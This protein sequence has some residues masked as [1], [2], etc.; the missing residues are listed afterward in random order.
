MKITLEQE[1]KSFYCTECCHEFAIFFNFDGECVEW[2]NR[3]PHAPCCG[4]KD[5]V[6][7]KSDYPDFASKEE[8]D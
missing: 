8:A 7:K 6:I 3:I 4:K 1:I 5:Y 2:V